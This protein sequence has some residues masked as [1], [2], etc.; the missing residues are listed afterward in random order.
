MLAFLR[1][2]SKFSDTLKR[3]GISRGVFVVLMGPFLS[4]Q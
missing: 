3:P 4:I 2:V 1:S